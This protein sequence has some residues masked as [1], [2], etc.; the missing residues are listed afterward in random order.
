MRRLFFALCA[1]VLPGAAFAACPAYDQAAAGY[2]L[3]DLAQ[4]VAATEAAVRVL[5]REGCSNYNAGIQIRRW[6]D[7]ALYHAWVR[8]GR[9][10]EL[11]AAESVAKQWLALAAL[12]DHLRDR[13]HQARDEG[14]RAEAEAL[15]ERAG[16]AY[17]RSKEDMD[18]LASMAAG[19]VRFGDAPPGPEAR[20]HMK[21][22]AQDMELLWGRPI[23]GR[24]VCRFADVAPG[25]APAAFPIVFAVNRFEIS[26]LTAEGLGAA[27]TLRDC[28]AR[29]PSEIGEVPVVG[30]AAQGNAPDPLARARYNC[31]LSIRRAQA[32]VE[33][34]LR[35]GVSHPM[36][37]VG[38]G[39]EVPYEPQGA[40]FDPRQIWAMSRR[41]EADAPRAGEAASQ[42]GSCRP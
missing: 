14:R 20:E 9:I 34:L 3:T 37:A 30:H 5:E 42:Q 36:R 23:A 8:T 6:A 2:V 21:R 19:G 41:V 13:G 10:A 17:H 12:G 32:V 31:A 25:M 22:A 1:V 33:F 24:A 29:L 18:F 35:G 28:L 39:E 38:R 16:R 40:G 11:E 27:E 15:Y 7:L 4:R 26:D